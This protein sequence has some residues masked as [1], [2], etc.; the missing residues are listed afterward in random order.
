MGNIMKNKFVIF[1]RLLVLALLLPA[2][3]AAETADM[4]SGTVFLAGAKPVRLYKFTM[5]GNLYQGAD[6]GI[7]FP[8][9]QAAKFGVATPQ[10][11]LMIKVN[12][13]KKI[14][15][16]AAEPAVAGAAWNYEAIIR[17]RDNRVIKGWVAIGNIWGYRSAEDK[18]TWSFDIAKG[19]EAARLKSVEFAAPPA[20]GGV[21]GREKRHGAAADSKKE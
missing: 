21:K 8:S 17:M 19:D 3:A 15:F 4:P 14:T 18:S 2:A 1:G 5:N 13:I 9:G 20:T 10:G 7:K 11:A 12:R 6:T 16:K